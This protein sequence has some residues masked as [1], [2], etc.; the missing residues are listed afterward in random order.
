MNLLQIGVIPAG[1]LVLFAIHSPWYFYLIYIILSA[2]IN[3]RFFSKFVVE[4]N[5]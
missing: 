4:K 1:L 3:F 2:E 5:A